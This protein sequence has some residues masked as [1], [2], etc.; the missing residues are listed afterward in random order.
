MKM[1]LQFPVTAGKEKDN[2]AIFFFPSLG[3]KGMAGLKQ[4]EKKVI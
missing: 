4:M 1:F 2:N 3:L